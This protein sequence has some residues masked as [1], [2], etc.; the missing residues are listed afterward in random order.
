MNLRLFHKM[1]N[2]APLQLGTKVLLVY[3]AAKF[4]KTYWHSDLTSYNRK[5]GQA[6]IPL[7]DFER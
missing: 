5:I 6:S 1:C 3:P 4:D 2:L 7:T